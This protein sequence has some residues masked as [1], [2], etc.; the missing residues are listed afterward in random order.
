MKRL[1]K[2]AALGIGGGV[3]V[4]GLA[5]AGLAAW[6]WTHYGHPDLPN[7][8]T[9][10]LDT[11]FPAWDVRERLSLEVAAPPEIVFRAACFLR[12]RQI[13]AVR[14]VFRTRELALSAEPS[15]QSMLS[16][17]EQ[18]R[19]WGWGVLS[20]KPGEEIIFGAVTQPW[21]A[22]PVFRALP[23]ESFAGFQQPGFVKI[24][25][26]LRV[27]PAQHGARVVTETRVTSNDEASRA[28]FRT[29]WALVMPGTYLIRWFALRA[30]RKQAED[31]FSRQHLSS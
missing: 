29:Y 30:I 2:L 14:A 16:L 20:E 18:A 13:P 21:E 4:A 3:A 11:L 7:E 22:N 23:A 25:W 1:F 17:V 8:A 5:Y 27:Q 12:L 28:H 24:A 19:A 6:T 31:A 26:T 15:P 9:D 10:S